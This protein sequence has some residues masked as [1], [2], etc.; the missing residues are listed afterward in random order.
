MRGSRGTPRA[1]RCRSPAPSDRWASASSPGARQASTK[2]KPI[3]ANRRKALVEG[4]VDLFILETFRD[5]NEIGAAIAAIR[6]VSDLPIVAQMTTEEDGN[7]LDGTPP[8][9]FAPELERRGADV[10]G[11][12]CSVGP[13]PMLETLERMGSAVEATLSAQPN[14]GR[15]RDI[16][17][18]TS[19][20]RRRN[21]WPR[22]PAG[23]SR[24]ACVWSVAAVARR[25]N[26]SG[27]SSWRSMR[28]RSPAA[29]RTRAPAA[30]HTRPLDAPRHHLCRAPRSRGLPT[31]LGAVCRCS[32]SK[33]SRREAHDAADV[34]AYAQTLKIRG[35]DAITLPTR[36]KSSARMS[37]LSLAV[38]VQQ[39]AGIEP[40]L[41]YACRDRYLLG[42]QSD[43]LGAHAIGIRN[44]VLFTGDPRKVGDYSDATSSSM[45]IRSV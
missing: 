45:W 24:R 41:Q 1:D 26:T 5:L 3:S 25:R 21:T 13:A 35:V 28:W 8:E 37:A 18:R 20:C 31:R 10:I 6:S 14:A 22:T 4:G 34:V 38:L 29:R 40:T 33:S 16:E 30:L 9:Q 44:L 7:S 12:N 42:M 39:Q 2:P 17:G 11:L 15:P 43:L 27:R 19:I 23:S 36:R 32:R